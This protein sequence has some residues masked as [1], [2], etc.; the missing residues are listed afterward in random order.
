M[1]LAT[2]P[3]SSAT[4][5]TAAALERVS[6]VAR[7][8]RLTSLG[9]LHRAL[10]RDLHAA[11]DFLRGRA[12]FGHRGRDGAADIA[13]FADRL[14]DSGDRCDRAL[15]CTLH[16]GDL[17]AD[18]LGRT[19]GL[20]G[21]RFYFAGHDGESTSGF[22][23]ARRLDRGIERQQIGL[24]G[25][26]GDELDHVADARSGFVQ[27]LDGKVGRFDFV[28][29]LGGDGVGLRDL[30]VDLVDR[31]RQ[32]IRGRSDVAHIGGSF[33][34]RLPPVRSWLEALS[35][36]ARELCRCSKHLI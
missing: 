5:F 26:V 14:L 9:G 17:R 36:A 21:K 25:N 29:R 10:C 11:R 16:A 18:F 31:C 27:L 8:I 30:T 6:C 22:A 34:R 12:L 24:L 19:A 13:D 20:P 23:G 4:I 33:R 32:L 15:G 28:H 3:R 1:R 7:P 2:L 35:A